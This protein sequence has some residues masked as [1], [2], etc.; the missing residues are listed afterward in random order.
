MRQIAHAQNKMDQHIIQ[1]I[2]RAVQVGALLLDKNA[3]LLILGERHKKRE[4]L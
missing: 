2:S 3:N 4:E 1:C